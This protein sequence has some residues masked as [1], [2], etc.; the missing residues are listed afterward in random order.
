MDISG[1]MDIEAVLARQPQ[2]VLVDELAH[3]NS[4]GSGQEKR[5]L[6]VE[7][8]LDANIDVLTTLNVQH[9]E[10]LNDIVF[11]ITGVRETETIPDEVV[12]RAAEIELV[13]LTE[14]GIRRRLTAGKIFPADEID[15]ALANYFR[16]GN[17]AA[18]RGIALSWTADRVEETLDDYRGVHEIDHPWETRERTLVALGGS[19]GGEFVIR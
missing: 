7:T 10:T 3:T 12:R 18:L 8:F 16:P 1:E 15:T 9:L 11:E 17:L 13:D 6:D 19:E 5:W 4:P 14:D 2:V